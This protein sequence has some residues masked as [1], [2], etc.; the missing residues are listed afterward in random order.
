MIFC[1]LVNFVIDT[2]LVLTYHRKLKVQRGEMGQG[3]KWDGIKDNLGENSLNEKLQEF[4][5]K[6]GVIRKLGAFCIRN[7]LL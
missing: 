5:F 7:D 6:V 1:I 3:G 2:P 4:R